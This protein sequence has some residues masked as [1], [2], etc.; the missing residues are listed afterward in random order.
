M[1]CRFP[2]CE[3]THQA[4]AALHYV[5][6]ERLDSLTVIPIV[7]EQP[8]TEPDVTRVRLV[9]RVDGRQR[10]LDV[11]PEAAADWSELLAAVDVRDL[12]AIAHVLYRA[13]VLLGA[14]P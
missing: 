12:S 2:W 4:D 14:N 8:G 13:G 7:A 3:S 1:S 11:T 9:F 5:I 10:E 6:A